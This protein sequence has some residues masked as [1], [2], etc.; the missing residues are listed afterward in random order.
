[1]EILKLSVKLKKNTSLII[2]LAFNN[3]QYFI[4]NLIIKKNKYIYNNLGR[5]IKIN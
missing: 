3:N 5:Y 2:I 1:M 4:E